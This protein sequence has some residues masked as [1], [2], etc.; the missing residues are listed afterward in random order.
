M[1]KKRGTKKGEREKLWIIFRLGSDLKTKINN[2]ALAKNRTM[3]GQTLE[4]LE[5]Y[6]KLKEELHNDLSN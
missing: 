2:L 1:A 6:F 5:N 3:N 4:I